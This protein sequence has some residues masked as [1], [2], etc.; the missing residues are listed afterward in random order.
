MSTK[1]YALPHLK[2]SI[3]CNWLAL[4]RLCVCWHK[5]VLRTINDLQWRSW[6]CTFFVAQSQITWHIHSGNNMYGMC[7]GVYV[8]VL[9][10]LVDYLLISDG[11]IILTKLHHVP[12]K[13]DKYTR[14]L[15]VIH[16]TTCN[17]CIANVCV[18][19][20]GIGTWKKQELSYIS[21]G[22]RVNAESLSAVQL[23]WLE[24]DKIST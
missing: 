7:L 1:L 2:R 18:V 23:L 14:M 16:C 22:R 13:N 8:C 6:W 5:S 9:T 4:G 11:D 19:L 10:C 21:N 12:K 3:R 24:L 20:I 15:I 17:T